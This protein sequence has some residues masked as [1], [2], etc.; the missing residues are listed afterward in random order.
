MSHDLHIYPF[1]NQ[2]VYFTHLQDTIMHDVLLIQKSVA[3]ANGVKEIRLFL[4]N[5][6]GVPGGTIT[7]DNLPTLTFG[8]GKGIKLEIRDEQGNG[9]GE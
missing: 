7:K 3:K 9:G 4:V 5:A 2:V 1:I 6:D 8:T